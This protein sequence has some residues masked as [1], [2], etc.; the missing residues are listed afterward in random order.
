[1]LCLGE[2]LILPRDNM[3]DK[4]KLNSTAQK[5]LDQAEKQFDSFN[6]QVKSMTQ[7]RMN[8]ECKSAENEGPKL[9]QKEINKSNDIYL[10]PIRTLASR[11]K[12]N[13]KFRADYEYAKEFVHFVAEHKEIIGEKIEVWTKPFP[14]VDAEYWEVPSNK[15][16][17][18]PRYLAEQIKK[19]SYHRLRTEDRVIQGD[20]YGSY[21]GN[22]VVD[23]KVQRLDAHPVNAKKSI[24]MSASG[25]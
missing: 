3:V 7:D 11:E 4:P 2:V 21:Y 1:M 14:G 15:P 16:V 12:F 6:D 20:G 9:S 22:L 19:C 5:E 17:W 13:E 8:A 10:K 25:F 23:A 24:F 18:G